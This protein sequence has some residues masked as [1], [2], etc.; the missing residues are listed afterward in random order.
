VLL[1]WSS[2][3]FIANIK[4]EARKLNI[5]SHNFPSLTAMLLSWLSLLFLVTFMRFSPLW[6]FLWYFTDH[7][8]LTV[9]ENESWVGILGYHRLTQTCWP[10]WKRTSI[11]ETNLKLDSSLTAHLLDTNIMIA[12]FHLIWGN[13][14]VAVQ[15]IIRSYIK[16]IINFSGFT[17]T[18]TT[19]SQPI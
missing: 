19:N 10:F 7:I 18:R 14:A 15:Q 2:I 13:F 16:H 11:S 8:S 17:W 6:C 4:D 9:L 3:R 12:L 5:N 1:F